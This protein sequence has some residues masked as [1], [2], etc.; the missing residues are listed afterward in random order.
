MKSGEF[1]YTST[2]LYIW[3]HPNWPNWRFDAAALA[4]PLAA[5]HRAQGK[6][7]GRMQAL[8][9]PQ[10]RLAALQMLSSDVLTTSEIEGEQLNLETVRSSFARRLNVDI[11]ALAP[12]D[13]HVDGVVDMV[14]DATQGYDQPLTQ[15]TT[16]NPHPNIC[17]G[18]ETTTSAHA[19]QVYVGNYY[20]IVPQSNS[21]FNRND[22]TEGQFLIGFN[23]TRLWN[24]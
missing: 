21:M 11:G 13:R 23:I 5:V 9:L 4:T 6:L 16:N 19:F 3:Q 24:Y 1:S 12:T 20:G 17:L 14:L 22:Y 2:N 10:R 18:I 15:H 7:A 8:G